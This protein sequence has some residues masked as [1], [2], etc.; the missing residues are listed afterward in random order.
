MSRRRICHFQMRRITG[1]AWFRL[2]GLSE[3]FEPIWLLIIY[4]SF[5]FASLIFSF[6]WTFD[7]ILNLEIDSELSN[8][9]PERH[10]RQVYG[11]AKASNHHTIHDNSR[12]RFFINIHVIVTNMYYWAH[13]SGW[14]HEIIRAPESDPVIWNPN[15]TGQD[16]TH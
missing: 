9:S 12:K 4:E 8:S 10:H 14:K 3:T 15:S 5:I 7:T 1:T 16:K 13:S 2:L 11:G 6:I